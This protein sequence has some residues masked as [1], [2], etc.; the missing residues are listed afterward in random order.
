MISITKKYTNPAIL[1]TLY[2]SI[3]RPHLEYCS[4]VHTCTSDSLESKAR[5]AWS[6]TKLEKN[7]SARRNSSHWLNS[8]PNH[9]TNRNP[10]LG[11]VA[12]TSRK[13]TYETSWKRRKL[14]LPPINPY[15]NF[16]VWLT[17][18]I[19]RVCHFPVKVK[20]FANNKLIKINEHSHHEI[21][22]LVVERV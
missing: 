8:N 5:W 15:S 16:V 11:S 13:S 20:N 3:I 1:T 2:K 9:K 17:A 18:T 7:C 19:I 14:N 12:F 10:A 6:L 22:I 4:N 21:F